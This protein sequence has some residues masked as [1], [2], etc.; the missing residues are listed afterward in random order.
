MDPEFHSLYSK[1]DWYG[2]KKLGVLY[3]L[4]GIEPTKGFENEVMILDSITFFS[5]EL[6]NQPAKL[7]LLVHG[8]THVVGYVIG[9]G[10]V[11]I[12]RIDADSGSSITSLHLHKI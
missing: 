11:E 7:V 12:S 3:D 10:G 8:D 1:Q 5:D 2:N 4:I 9:K 6:D